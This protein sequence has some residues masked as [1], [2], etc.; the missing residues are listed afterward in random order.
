MAPPL[1][2]TIS[3]SRSSS[4]MNRSGTA[5]NASFTSN[6]EMSWAARPAL[7]RPCARPP[8]GR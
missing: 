7:A 8:P 3:G 4:R 5:E 2:F 1:T 6:S